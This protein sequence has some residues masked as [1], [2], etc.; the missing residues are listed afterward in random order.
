MLLRFGTS[1]HRSIRD[2]Q[3]IFFTASPLKGDELA[4]LPLPEN[5]N[6]SLKLRGLPVVALYGANASGKSALI[7]AM[8]TFVS[9]VSW[10]QTGTSSGTGTPYDP[11]KLDRSSREK[12]SQYDVDFILGLTRY[13]Y[14]FTLDKEVVISEWLYS[15]SLLSERQTRSILFHRDRHQPDSFYFGKS[16]KGDNKRIA[17]LARANS[18]FLSAAAQNAHPT[19]QPIFDYFFNRVSRRMTINHDGSRHIGEQPYNYFFNDNVRY[20]KVI[21]FLRA[22][23]VGI[24]KID[25]SKVPLTET[26]KKLMEDINQLLSKHVKNPESLPNRSD[27]TKVEILHV[28]EDGAQYPIPL[29]DESSGTLALLQLLGP[30]F[31][32]LSEGGVLIVDELNVA[33]HPLISRELV[34]LFSKPETN[35]GRAQLIFSTHDTNIL[36]SGLMRRDQIWFAEKDQFGAT[37]IYSL[38]SIKVRSTDNWERGYITGRFGAIPFLG[39][40][41]LLERESLDAENI[42]RSLKDRGLDAQIEAALREM[43]N[44]PDI[45]VGAQ[46]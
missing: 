6:S 1:N 39:A 35:P 34:G 4:L 20:K 19:L 46:D 5:A 40:H 12:P 25:F 44:L 22:A 24:T 13:H 17:K 41:L 33:L 28:G 16:L 42:N 29:D 38:S 26:K 37:S 32:R 30:V 18:L 45:P 11:F 3:E 31:D 14:G 8:D 21:D 10:S 23:D 9:I 27:E 7:D 43:S 36:T 2:Y 15:Y